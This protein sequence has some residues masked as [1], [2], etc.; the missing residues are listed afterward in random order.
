MMYSVPVT[1]ST[2]AVG[3]NWARLPS[4]KL[5]TQLRLALLGEMLLEAIDPGRRDRIDRVIDDGGLDQA[6]RLEHFAGIG[7]RRPRDEGAAVLLDVDD[8]L[9]RKLLERS[10]DQRAARA[11]DLADLVLA[12]LRARQQAMLEDRG[13]HALPDPADAIVRIWRIGF[14]A[15]FGGHLRVG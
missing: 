10:A 15:G 14:R 11:V 3:M 5:S 12:E 6:A 13:G 8:A 7:R 4:E 2:A 9:M 1:G